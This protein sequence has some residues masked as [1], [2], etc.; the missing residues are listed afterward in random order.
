MP[1]RVSKMPVRRQL[2]LAVAATATVMTVSVV[3]HIKSEQAEE[4]AITSQSLQNAATHDVLTSEV[5]LPGP[6]TPATVHDIQQADPFSLIAVRGEDL[7]SVDVSVRAQ[8]TDGSWGQWYELD[9]VESGDPAAEHKGIPAATE[10]VFVGSTH[11]AQ[12]AVQPKYGAN[13]KS[14]KTDNRRAPAD[15][16][17]GYRPASIEQPL[18]TGLDAI[19]ISPKLAPPDAA[20]FEERWSAPVALPQAGPRIITRAQWGANES[21][22]CPPVYNRDVRAGVVHHT[23]GSNNY[24]PYDSA[25]IIRAIYAYHTKT[26]KWCDI[27]YNVLVDKYGQIFEGRFG[28][29]TNNVQ[30]AH[31][32][33]FNE[34]SWGIALIGDF[35]RDEPSPAMLQAAGRILGWRLRLAGVDPRGQVDLASEGGP[36]TTVPGGKVVTLPTIFTHRDVGNTEC[37]GEAAYR[38]IPRLRDIA[39]GAA[40]G[41]PPDLVDSLR[42]GAIYDTWTRL[43]SAESDL[44]APTSVE[45]QAVG[46]ARFATFR[47][48][49]MYFSPATGTHPVVG[50]IYHAWAE[51]D[52]E[53]G[54][55]GLPVTDEIGEPNIIV[56]NFQNGSLIYDR[57]S[58]RV[59]SVING[60]TREILGVAPVAQNALPE[61]FSAPAAPAAPPPPAPAPPPPPPPVEQFA[62]AN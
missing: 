19:L 37:P 44:G 4:T 26:L 25:A 17:L 11:S 56:Q 23:A 50:A 13:V 55:L 38:L 48:G 16:G 12:V 36:F 14:P 45:Q 47:N 9:P 42:G 30:G 32:G 29:I 61:Q 31:T 8:Q 6:S 1:M 27:A 5:G 41:E 49:A 46:E 57:A 51:T 59:S 40:N 28:G 33:G 53:R 39:A 3:D 52:F 58:G 43:G 24:S 34:H 62:P 60:E 35:T 54:P 22:R 15:P 20:R 2:A 7:S 18:T 21:D 10:P